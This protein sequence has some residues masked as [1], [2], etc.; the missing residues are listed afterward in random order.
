[1]TAP[2]IGPRPCPWTD[3]GCTKV[4]R[5][6]QRSAASIHKFTCRYAPDRE[7]RAQKLD[8]KTNHN[9]TWQEKQQNNTMLEPRYTEPAMTTKVL[10]TYDIKDTT[11]R[12]LAMHPEHPVLAVEFETEEGVPL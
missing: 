3:L 2:H 12:H 8:A 4:H 6:E 10:K 11:G 7:L 9:I 1:M 5:Q